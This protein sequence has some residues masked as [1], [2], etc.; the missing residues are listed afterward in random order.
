MSSCRV[1]DWTAK[2]PIAAHEEVSSSSNINGSSG[3]SGSS[4]NG[5]SNFVHFCGELHEGVEFTRGGQM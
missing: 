1:T 5:D 4:I 2:P 3:S